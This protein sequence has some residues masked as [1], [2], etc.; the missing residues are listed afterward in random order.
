M[1][2]NMFH[3]KNARKLNSDFCGKTQYIAFSAFKNVSLQVGV[4]AH[5]LNPRN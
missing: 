3:D 4:V 1:E 5:A 2:K